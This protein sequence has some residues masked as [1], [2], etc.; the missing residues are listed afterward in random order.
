MKKMK[1]KW[2]KVEKRKQLLL[3]GVYSS[4]YLWTTHCVMNSSLAQSVMKPV[5]LNCLV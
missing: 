3:P 5:F 1:R 2:L 4:Q